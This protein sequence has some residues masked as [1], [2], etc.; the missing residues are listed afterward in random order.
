MLERLGVAAIV[1]EVVGARRSDEL[2]SVETYIA[3]STLNR[4]LAPC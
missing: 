1:D 3:L 4:V 2:A